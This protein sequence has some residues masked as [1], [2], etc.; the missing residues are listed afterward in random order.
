MALESTI[1]Q[2]N[3]NLKGGMRMIKK[4]DMENSKLGMGRFLRGSGRKEG[5]RGKEF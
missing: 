5:E 2:I 3:L 1:G 4:T